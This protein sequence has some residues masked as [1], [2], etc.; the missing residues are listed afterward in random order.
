MANP[1]TKM[2]PGDL[3]SEQLYSASHPAGKA[4]TNRE[5]VLDVGCG[6]YKIAGAI[7]VDHRSAQGV[8]VICDLDCLPWPFADNAFDRAIC[9]HSLAHMGNVV[10]AMEELHRILRP[11]GVLEILTPHFSSDNAFTDITSRWFFGARSMN[12]FC[13]NRM[14]KYRYGR[15]AYELLEVRISF[16]EARVFEPAQQK[17]NP[18]KAMG[19]EALV[20]RFPRFYEHFLALILRA[21]EIYY[22]LR[23]VK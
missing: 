1:T 11:G 21:N 20:N 14:M 9:R 2:A 23:V 19:I 15:G 17:P 10:R 5:R 18:F 16:R 12:Y 22:R 4:G 8:D 3:G 7:G 6:P 13:T